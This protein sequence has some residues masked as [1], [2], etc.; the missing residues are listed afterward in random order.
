MRFKF[1]YNFFF[2]ILMVL[3]IFSNNHLYASNKNILLIIADD[4]G[5]EVF[6]GY[7]DSNVKAHLPNLEK[8]MKQGIRFSNFWTYPTCTPTRSTIITGK[9]GFRTNV[10]NVRDRLSLK[11][12]SLQKI[13]RKKTKNLYNDAVIGKWH[14]SRNAHHP[15]NLGISYYA[16]LLTGSVT[17]YS[18]W[19]LTIQGKTTNNDTYITTKLTDL[20]INWIKNQKKP[21]FLWLAYTAPHKP[22]H[23]P[24]KNLFKK[25]DFQGNMKNNPKLKYLAMM[26]SMDTEVG[27]L[28]SSMSKKSLENTVILF[29]GD[30]GTP[31][32][33]ITGYKKYQGKGSLYQGGINTP[34]FVSGKFVKRK[35]EI[36]N[37]LIN[38]TDLFATILELAGTNI[39]QMHDSKSVV[40]LFSNQSHMHRKYVYSEISSK[41]YSGFTIR[42]NKYKYIH[43]SNKK[44]EL[45]DILSDPL[46]TNNLINSKTSK[47]EFDQIISKFLA[48]KNKEYNK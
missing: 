14:L 2:F 12:L 32:R 19:P 27:R 10:L 34:F 35:N 1:R 25:E 30:N 31:K 47:I 16:G 45:Y 46:E 17:N 22:F 33:V 43:Y 15:N 4:I 36:D 5:V 24:P 37:S 42:D 48:I 13:L 40:H 28:L 6:P 44:Y 21:W 41:N 23:I 29:I 18:N 7:K 9:F 3:T 20:A 39:T 11:E 8:L 38:S 26:Q